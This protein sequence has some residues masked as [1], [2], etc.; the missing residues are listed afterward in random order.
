MGRVGLGGWEQG[1]TGERSEVLQGGQEGVERLDEGVQAEL[2][3][4]AVVIIRVEVMDFLHAVHP[5]EP[6]VFA[7]GLNVFL[8]TLGKGAAKLLVRDMKGGLERS[9]G[10]EG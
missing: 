9:E 3:E 4:V 10:Q 2:V 8:A 6:K 7:Q 1:W 5:K